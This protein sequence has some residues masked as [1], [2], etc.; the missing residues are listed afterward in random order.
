[1][2]PHATPQLCSG[3]FQALR[4]SREGTAAATY[5][6]ACDPSSHCGLGN[7]VPQSW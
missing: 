2:E 7:F 4:E 1:M 6:G 3:S 5:Y